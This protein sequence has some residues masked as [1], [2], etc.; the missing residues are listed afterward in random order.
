[1]KKIITISILLIFVLAQGQINSD[2]NEPKSLYWCGLDF[3][4]A[5]MIGI[6]GFK[7]ADVIANEYIHSK[8]NNIIFDEPGKYNIYKFCRKSQASRYSTGL[9]DVK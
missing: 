4:K 2:L 7:N 3:S 1:M 9:V 5:K 8:W 6:K